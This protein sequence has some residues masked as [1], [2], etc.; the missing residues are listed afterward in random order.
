[1]KS[2]SNPSIGLVNLH[3]QWQGEGERIETKAG[4]NLN[5]I[6]LMPHDKAGFQAGYSV[7]TTLKPFRHA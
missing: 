3:R 6:L 7:K 1:M 2:T 4:W 5:A